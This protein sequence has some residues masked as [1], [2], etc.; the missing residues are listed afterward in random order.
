MRIGVIG[1]PG[2][3]KSTVH[4][5]LTGARAAGQR[6][7]REDPGVTVV[8]V[9]D[10]RVDRL[11]EMFHPRRTVYA[12]VEF[13]DIGDLKAGGDSQGFAPALLAAARQV[14]ALAVVLAAFQ[15]GDDPAS[16]LEEIELELSFADL[17][18][19]EKRL[20]RLSADVRKGPVSSRPLLLQEQTLLERLSQ[21][22]HAGTSIRELD[23]DPEE[24]RLL[25]GYGFLS[26]KPAFAIL[27][28]GEDMRAGVDPSALPLPSVAMSGALEAEL[29]ELDPDEAGEFLADLGLEERGINRVIRLAYRTARL[30]SFFTVGPDEVR[31]WTTSEGASAVDAASVIHTDLGRGL[32]RAE[33]VSYPDLLQA[34]GLTEA[35]K[36]GVLRLEGKAYTVQ[37]GD[38]CHFLSNV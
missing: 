14:D 6:G 33:V 3:G 22:L 7:R 18:V 13:S 20:E 19:I 27:N 28:V 35:K 4:Q 12:T 21:S 36:L 29:A 25:R 38:I 2:V 23:I 34:G 17:A 31:A 30:L 1:L 37:D 24:K 32:I 16:Q 8:R 15:P 26:E 10:E 5:A 11:S 9:P